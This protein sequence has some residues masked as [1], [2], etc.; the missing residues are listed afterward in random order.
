MDRRRHPRYP[1]RFLV[2]HRSNAAVNDEAYQVDYVR[3]VSRSGLFIETT[4]PIEPSST[5]QLNFSPRRDA[6][7]ISAFC[8]VTHQTPT[9]VGAEFVSLDA[10]ALALLEG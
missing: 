9:G 5:L 4:T 3:D 7:L 2:Q 1:A 10:D 8:R 6:S